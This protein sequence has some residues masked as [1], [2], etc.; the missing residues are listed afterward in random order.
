MSNPITEEANEEGH[1]ASPSID[2]NRQEVCRCRSETCINVS[3]SERIAVGH[4]GIPS[5][6]I[7]DDNKVIFRLTC[8][9]VLRKRTWLMIVGVNREKA[10][11]GPSL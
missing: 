1:E 9:S 6:G 7:V 11:R 3:K 4:A 10:N 2:R 8:T 5:C